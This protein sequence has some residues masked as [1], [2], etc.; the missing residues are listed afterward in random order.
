[1]DARIVASA[2][3]GADAAAETGSLTRTALHPHGAIHAH[4]AMHARLVARGLHS[5][6]TLH[7]GPLVV[8]SQRI[9][10]SRDRNASKQRN[11]RNS[12]H[13]GLHYILQAWSMMMIGAAPHT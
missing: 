12:C 13:Q 9:L 1:M 8:Q 4:G 2:A 6:N 10:C 3:D 5:R 7:H 11:R